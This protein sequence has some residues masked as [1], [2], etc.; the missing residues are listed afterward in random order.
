M[1][2]L[3]K[4]S[5]TLGLSIVRRK[6]SQDE[7]RCTLDFLSVYSPKAQEIGLYDGVMRSTFEVIENENVALYVLQNLECDRVDFIGTGYLKG[8]RDLISKASSDALSILSSCIG[9]DSSV[10][11]LVCLWEFLVQS[12]QYRVKGDA[13][14]EIKNIKDGAEFGFKVEEPGVIHLPDR[15]FQINA[16]SRL[17]WRYFGGEAFI[18]N[19]SHRLVER[20]YIGLGNCHSLPAS[21]VR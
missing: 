4:T 2:S 7:Q 1:K 15:R 9:N 11:K 3:K 10:V 20:E 14:I 19:L 12:Y 8:G 21:E 13:P 18:L 17:F 16:E 6:L 5:E